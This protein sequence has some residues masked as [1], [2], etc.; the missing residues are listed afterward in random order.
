VKSFI[1]RNTITIHA[2][3]QSKDAAASVR[4]YNAPQPPTAPSLP[5]DLA[6]ELSKFDAQE[7]EISSA[8]S[9]A[10]KPSAA[11]S[12]EGGESAEEYLK[13]LEKD[14]PKADAHH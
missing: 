11:A 5:T 7:P 13:F 4:S 10:S 6:A 2:N 12:A 9:S 1:T 14:L 3:I 8:S